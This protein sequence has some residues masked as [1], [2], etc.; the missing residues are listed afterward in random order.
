MVGITIIFWSDNKMLETINVETLVTAFQP[1]YPFAVGG[2][3]GFLV[4]KLLKLVIKI[5]AVIAGGIIMLLGTLSYFGM[6]SVNFVKVENTIVEGSKVAANT[7]Y[8]ILQHVNNN[9]L[10]NSAESVMIGGSVSFIAGVGLAL[11]Y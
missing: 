11:K 7:T 5:A 2:I 1:I 3:S 8:D 6:I 9:F 10:A 4:G